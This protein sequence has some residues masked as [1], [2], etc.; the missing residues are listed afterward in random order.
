MNWKEY[1]TH[2]KK[3]LKYE[4]YKEMIACS[5]LELSDEITEF[6]EHYL[7]DSD[8]VLLLK[9][10]GDITYPLA[11]LSDH[12][13]IEIKEIYNP[14]LLFPHLYNYF[15]DNAIF[16]AG[17]IAGIIKK[18]IR[19]SSYILDDTNDRRNNLT[20]CMQSLYSIILTHCRKYEI[21]FSDVLSLN[22]EKLNDR[23]KRGVI[24]GSGDD[25]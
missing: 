9:E 24:Q 17:K 16:I 15:E 11:I 4:S 21:N 18:T 12:Y 3:T 14:Y 23:D 13:N 22:I 5:A 1:Q 25:R 7:A 6:V 2:C 10:L 8:E 20:Y 19:D